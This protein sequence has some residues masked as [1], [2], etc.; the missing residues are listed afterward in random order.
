MSTTHV[1]VLLSVLLAA[2][3]VLLYRY[4]G[5]NDIC[6]GTPIAN[7][8]YG[9]TE[10]LIGMFVNTLVLRSQ[11]T[12]G[13]SFRELMAQVK[14]MCLEAYEHQDAPFEKVVELVQPQ[15]QTPAYTMR[16]TKVMEKYREGESTATNYPSSNAAKISDFGN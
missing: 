16:R 2:V 5:Q 7:R 12:G 8:Q 11:I 1:L 6:V 15:H 9:E 10:G 4:T 3:K 13:D 14:A